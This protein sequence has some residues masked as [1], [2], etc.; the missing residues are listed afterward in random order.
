MGEFVDILPLPIGRHNLVDMLSVHIVPSFLLAELLAGIDQEHAAVSI[1][2]F[3]DDD[4]GRYAGVEEDTC[5]EANHGIDTAVFQQVL[6]DGALGSPTE[7][8]TM[9]QDDAHG[10]VFL[11][12]IETM[13][14]ESKVSFCLGSQF[15]IA[16]EAGGCQESGGRAPMLAVRWIHDSGIVVRRLFRWPVGSKSVAVA[17]VLVGEGDIVEDHVHA[18]KVVCGMG[19]LLPEILHIVPA[20]LIH[21]VPGMEKQGA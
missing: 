6:A 2:L 5:R 12:V 4:A 14:K 16:L 18:C 13:Q 1:V 17:K 11:Q 21:I 3:E 20:I 9:G 7:Q 19:N 8:D 15:L 10:A